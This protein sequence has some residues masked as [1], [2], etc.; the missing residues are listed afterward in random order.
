MSHNVH[1]LTEE[2]GFD[3]RAPDGSILT[4]TSI[5]NTKRTVKLYRNPNDELVVAPWTETTVVFG[6]E[7]LFALR[8]FLAEFPE[9]AFVRPADPVEKPNWVD[10]DYVDSSWDHFGDPF[11]YAR[12]DGR[13]RAVGVGADP[14]WWT[15]DAG[16]DQIL[17]VEL[18]NKVLVKGGVQQ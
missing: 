8:E 3:H 9:E 11:G 7:D 15:D 18:G 16:I 6:G 14:T 10:G 2:S 12:V 13:W 4:V 17:R 1:P 5:R